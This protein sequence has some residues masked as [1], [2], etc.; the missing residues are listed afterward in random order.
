LQIGMTCL[1]QL[2]PVQAASPVAEQL[3]ASTG[4]A[5]ALALWGNFG[6]TIVRMIEAR[7]PLLGAMRA[8]IVMSALGTAT[9][10]AFSGALPD[11]RVAGAIAGALGDAPLK[12]RRLT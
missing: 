12:A 11:D 2:D 8:A 6:A 3:A 5:V 9:G 7:Q 1:H 10:R 4:Y